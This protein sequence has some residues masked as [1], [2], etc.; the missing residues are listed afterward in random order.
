MA[1]LGFNLNIRY[2]TFNPSSRRFGIA[3]PRWMVCCLLIWMLG[4]GVP[5]AQPPAPAP[6]EYQ[7]KAAFL[8][9]FAQFVDWPA[10]A[11]QDAQAPLVIGILGDDP[12]DASLDDIIRGEKVNNR[13]L[14]VQRYRRVADMKSCHVLFVSRSED[15]RMER[16]LAGLKDKAILTVGESDS[17][18]EK[19]GM[20]RFTNERNK[21]RLRINVD[22]A[23]EARLTISS[24]LLRL[25]E[26]VKTE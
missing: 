16:T 9:N 18:F 14:V 20:I 17:F 19:G 11:F 10:E 8:Y 5:S 24:K 25:A 21:I 1:V 13:P 15:S 26:V 22:A 6:S 12:F 2:S 3:G 4:G 7:I 23:R